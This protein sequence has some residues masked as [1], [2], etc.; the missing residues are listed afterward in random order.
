[1]T[2][3]KLQLTMSLSKVAI[4]TGAC[5]GIGLGTLKLL[6]SHGAKVASFD[7]AK[8]LPSEHIN[9]IHIECEVSQHEQVE[10]SVAI[11]YDKWKRID[12]LV[13]CAGVLDHF[14]KSRSSF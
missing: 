12:I 13:N 7:I 1:M 6:L 4:V 11:V 14:G 2:F 3:R 5:S 10:K 9:A 8:T